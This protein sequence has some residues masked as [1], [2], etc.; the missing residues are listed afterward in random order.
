M[1]AKPEE[2]KGGHP[3]DNIDRTIHSPARLLIIAH[4][5]VVESADFTF[6]LHQTGL[7]RGNLSAQLR[8]LEEA[9]YIDIKKEFVDNVPRTLASLTPEGRRAIDDYRTTMQNL[10]DEFLGS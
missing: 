8:N 1:T 6:L 2:S 7:T 9:G 4:L 5:A 3:I 10:L